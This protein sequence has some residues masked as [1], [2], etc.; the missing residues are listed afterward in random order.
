MCKCQ[1]EGFN[2]DQGRLCPLRSPITYVGPRLRDRIIEA[3]WWGVGIGAVGVLVLL[4]FA[5]EVGRWPNPW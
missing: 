5:P 1:S 4:A 2:C 3:V